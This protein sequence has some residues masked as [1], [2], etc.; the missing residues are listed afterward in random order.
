MSNEYPTQQPTMDDREAADNQPREAVTYAEDLK[1]RWIEE[2]KKNRQEAMRTFVA[3]D[4]AGGADPE[5]SL[6]QQWFDYGENVRYYDEE[7][8]RMGVKP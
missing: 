8:E 1:Q 6:H 3:Y 4:K 2:L 7:L 5:S